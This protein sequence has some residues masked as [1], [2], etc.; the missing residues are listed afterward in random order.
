[1]TTI[2]IRTLIIYACLMITMRFMGKRQ[3]GELE[4]SELITTLLLSEIASLPI[5]NQDLPLSHA[6]LPIITLMALE[7]VLSGL[8]LKLPFLKKLL[9]VRPA[10][11]IHHGKIDRDTMRNIRISA[12]ELISQLRLKDVT[13]PAD[14]EYAILEPNGQISVIL[15]ASA[16]PATTQEAGVTVPERGIMHLLVADGQVN[17]KNLRMAGKDRAWLDQYLKK[18][19]LALE[20]IFL[21]MADDSGLVRLHRRESL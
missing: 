7:V 1:M 3:L 6:L 5:T 14:V 16:R 21:L 9:S 8:T 15:S 12:D 19:R 20:D 10:I 13:D 2:M 18:E 11:L 4:V 17:E